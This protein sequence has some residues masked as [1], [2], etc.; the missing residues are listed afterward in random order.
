MRGVKDQLSISSPFSPSPT[1]QVRSSVSH[2]Y[3]VCLQQGSFRFT[4][5]IP[6]DPL[7]W[8][9]EFILALWYD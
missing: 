7:N 5:E 9:P 3:N 6:L 2:V 1:L 4:I 8:G